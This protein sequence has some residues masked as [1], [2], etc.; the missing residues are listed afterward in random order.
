[1]PVDV[2]EV[3]ELVSTL[4]EEENLRVTVTECAKAGLIAGVATTVGG[5]VAGPIGL[6]FGASVGGVIAYASTKKFKSAVQ[7]IADMKQEDKNVLAQ[8]VRDIMSNVGVSDIAVFTA[9]LSS[10]E[11]VRRKVIM[12]L[13]IY[14]KNELSMAIVDH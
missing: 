1:M 2:R 6:L 11:S 9:M 3:I 5:V 12:T 13:V 10:D 14:L 4:S 7:V 8:R